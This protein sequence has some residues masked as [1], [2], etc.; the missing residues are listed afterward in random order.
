M[1]IQIQ[2]QLGIFCIGRIGWKWKV[3]AHMKNPFISSP[4]SSSPNIRSF[5]RI[6][7]MLKNSVLDFFNMV[8]ALPTSSME[9][10]KK[11]FVFL[12]ET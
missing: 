2:Q 7:L 10:P 5:C 1:I 4:G 9:L 11:D 6:I 3:L 8:D 12:G